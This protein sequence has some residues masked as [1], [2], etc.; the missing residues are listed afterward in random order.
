[1]IQYISKENG[2]LKFLDEWQ[3]GTWINIIPPNHKDEL[4]ELSSKFNIPLDFLT[5]PLDIE[6]RARYEWEDEVK[7][8]IINIPF[9][10]KDTD[11]VE[12]HSYYKT[13]P[14][15]LILTPYNLITVSSKENNIIQRILDGKVKN[16][17]PSNQAHSILKILEQTVLWYLEYLKRLNYKRNMLEQELY[18]SSRNRELKELLKIEK[19]L[20]YFLNSLK[21][22]ELLL[23]KMKRTDFLKI[24]DNE[25]Y[26]DYFEDIIIDYSQGL[27]MANVH[28][29]ILGGIMDTY[30]TIISNN[31]N[32]F[33]QRLTFIT[34][35]LEVPTLVASFYGMNVDLPFAGFKY[36]FYILFGV[37]FLLGIFLVWMITKRIK[38]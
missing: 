38:I 6:E 31:F 21:A 19:S 28:T 34:I 7:L 22:D 11:E 33:I 8:I 3:E 5:D 26:V 23:M 25:D 20:V 29:N 2:E 37:S 10:E 13:I 35:I 30:A 16:F 15:G 27:D 17:Q 18:N 24:R 12:S 9:K 32:N 36:I 14:L 4:E 1:M